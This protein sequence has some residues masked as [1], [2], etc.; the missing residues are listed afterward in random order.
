MKGLPAIPGARE[1]LGTAQT[2]RAPE[3]GHIDRS[4]LMF[5]EFDG[6]HYAGHAG[7]TLASALLANGI[8]VFGRS[9]KYHRPRGVLGAYGEEPNALVTVGSGARHEPNLRATQ[10]E[11]YDGLV[12]T[13]QHRWPSLEFDIGSL[14]DRIA[15]VLPAGFYYK[16]FMWPGSWWMRYEHVIRRAA[17]L[18][19][20]PQQAD[21]DRY[22][23]RHAHCDVLVVGGGPAGLVAAARAAAAGARVMLVDERSELGGSLWDEP[24]QLDGTEGHLWARAQAEALRAEGVRVLTRACAFGYYDHNLVAIVERLTDHLAPATSPRPRQRLWW[25]R[26]AQVVLAT[27]AIERPLVFSGNDCPGVMLASAARTYAHRYAVR[28]GQHAVLF[29][30]NDEAYDTLAALRR[31]GTS[32][33]MVVDARPGGPGSAAREAVEEAGCELAAGFAVTRT[34]GRKSLRAVQLMAFDNGRLSGAPRRLECDLLCL[35]GGFNPTVHLYSQ[36]RGAIR[37]DQQLAAF[38]PGESRQAVQ[39]VGACNG[40]AAMAELLAEAAN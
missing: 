8:R 22:V 14:N 10:V 32:V 6:R 17:G 33:S 37:Y 28:S 19:H 20:A 29:T 36:S 21:P 34:Y 24:L 4:R 18:G 5:F 13:S 11:L 26:A 15:R 38:V 9:F 3:G 31:A 25:V 30:N 23:R 2:R 39:A 27:G 35:S 16:T 40:T 12:A 1:A 7:D